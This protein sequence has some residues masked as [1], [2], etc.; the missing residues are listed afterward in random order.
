[1]DDMQIVAEIN[2]LVETEHRL[3][4]AHIGRGLSESEMRFL[5]AVEVH[6]DQCWD[7]LRQRRARR[8]AGLD[9][10]QADAR[11]PAVVEQYRQ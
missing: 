5:R 4:R 1:M 10:D 9:P 3:E 6:I 7:L 11:D 2:R 8:S